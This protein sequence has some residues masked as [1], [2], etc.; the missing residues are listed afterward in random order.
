MLDFLSREEKWHRRA[1]ALLFGRAWHPSH[2]KLRLFACACCRR[3]CNLSHGGPI[4]DAVETSERYAD[5]L[6]TVGELRAAAERC[7]A[8]L[9]GSHLAAGAW[10]A[11]PGVWEAV[12][13]EA[14]VNGRRV[15]AG[16]HNGDLPDPP[17]DAALF[18]SRLAR[19][20][21]AQTSLLRDIIGPLRPSPRIPAS[22]FSWN[23]GCAVKVATAAY[24]E[25]R[26]DGT[27]DGDR[28]AVL[29]DALEEAGCTDA[30]ILSHCR[31]PGPHVRG[32]WA[33][34]M[35]LGKE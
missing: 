21:E 20:Q 30:A 13:F 22:A 27:V 15:A 9:G 25:R 34:D 11:S 16:W 32:C 14:D 35:L 4:R 29:A 8:W 19:E 33:V 3:G 7:R 31:G 23:D 24:D 26:P 18:S 10:V 5:G 12:F 6:A 1:L 17:P 28:L 2:R